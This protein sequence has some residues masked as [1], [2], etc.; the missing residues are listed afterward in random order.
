MPADVDPVAFIL[1]GSRD[2]A[3]VFAPFEHD[4]ANIGAAEEFERGGQPG[5][6][7]ADDNCCPFTHGGG[8]GQLSTSKNDRFHR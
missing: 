5:G 4:N 3:H 2:S 7:R 6:A 8:Q 1:D